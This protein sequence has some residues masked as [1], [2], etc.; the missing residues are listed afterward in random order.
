MSQ[1]KPDTSIY[2]E[3]PT[4]QPH[5]WTLVFH[6]TPV[7]FDREFDLY[8]ALDIAAQFL[9]ETRGLDIQWYGPIPPDLSRY[10]A[11]R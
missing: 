9:Q 8:T 5:R 2:L 6:G 1:A 7:P 10:Y 11:A 4:N 3:S